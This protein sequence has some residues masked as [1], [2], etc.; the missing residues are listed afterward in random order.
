MI[1][2]DSAQALGSKFK[3]KNAGTF[4]SAGAFSFYPAKVLPCLGDGGIVVTN[5]DSMAE[6]IYAL[7]EHG[8]DKNGE[9]TGWGMNSR[10]DNMQAAF[11]NFFLSIYDSEIVSKRRELAEHY[12]QRL[13]DCGSIQLPPLQAQ[14]P[15]ISMFFKTMRS[16]LK[17]VIPCSNIFLNRVSELL[18]NGMGRRFTSFRN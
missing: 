7:H 8:R 11:L 13:K 4:G 3:N 15:T 14:R 16:N 17:T 5:D 12:H 18:G 10:L 9:M 1:I 2:E 6:K